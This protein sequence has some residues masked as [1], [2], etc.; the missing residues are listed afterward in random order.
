MQ[1][2]IG[3]TLLC[4]G[5]W[6][7]AALPMAAANPVRTDHVEVELVT[8]RQA[9]VAGGTTQM[10][11]RQDLEAG[12]HTYWRNPGDSGES[13]RIDWDLPPGVS[14][15]PF[16]WPAPHRLPLGPLV[17]YGYEGEV[18]LP[19]TVTLE[20][21]IQGPVRLVAHASWL[22]CKDICIPE[23][24]KLE[25][26]V[27][28][29]PRPTP[30]AWA[31]R[32]EAVLAAAPAPRA[33]W[34][35]HWQPTATGATLAVQ[36]PD[37]RPETVTKGAYFYP[38]DGGLIDHS[39]PQ[40]LRYGPEG[41]QI[42][43]PAGYWLEKGPA[44]DQITGVVVLDAPGQTAVE[45]K[46]NPGDLPPGTTGTDVTVSEHTAPTPAKVTLGWAMGLA[47]V[48]G[49][50]LNLMPCVF[51]VLSLKA[52]GLAQHAH[53]PRT[54]RRQGLVFLLGVEVAFLALASVLIVLRATGEHL[55][56]GFQLQSPPVVAALMV[57]MLAIGLN[58]SGV[59]E[60][61]GR[62]QVLGNHRHDPDSPWG[63]FFTGLLAVVVA[64]PCTAP[65]MGTALGFAATQTPPVALA[66]FAALGL[67][68]ALPL[69]VLS[70]VPALAGRLPR[71]GAW[72]ETFRQVLA[73]PMYG[74]A[75]WL[76]WVLVRQSGG[77]LTAMAIVLGVV[78]AFVL[79]AYGRYQRSGHK[80][81]LATLVVGLLALVLVFVQ[82]T[83][84]NATSRLAPEPYSA[85]RLETLKAEGAP[86]FLYFT[87]AWCVTCLVN[88]RVALSADTVQR[89]LQ[90]EGYTVL[91]ADWTNKDPAITEALA[92]Y[93]RNG[94]PLYVI[95]HPDVEN[96]VILPQLLTPEIVKRALISPENH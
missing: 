28:V 56:W 70:F 81:M 31:Q 67:G 44:P 53:Q 88:E 80:G 69:L 79:W 82:I 83:L 27:P 24:A 10:A 42:D 37:F 91:K 92:K 40:A 62:L 12:W 51:P 76:L 72:M 50:I 17:N 9:L 38:Y 58:L 95:H 7:A 35:T 47:L 20:D 66:V 84:P 85:Q 71:P 22:V 29:E 94:V 63:A 57:V 75:G 96:E 19:F 61:G 5:L 18:L 16:T 30:T 48:G 11:L 36:V 26:T 52:T 33:D 49:I 1:R 87:A 25:I 4:F 45:V 89:T 93:G 64:A 60:M 54:L 8:T 6:L 41:F 15:S 78:T 77:E 68:L 73:F 2:R 14:I 23:E 32:I 59:F 86:V 34:I 21:N 74:A 55:G 39:A 65:F 3:L 90:D 43:L 13:T 46:A